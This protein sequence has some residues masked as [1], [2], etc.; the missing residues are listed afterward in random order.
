M[1]HIRF[2]YGSS[3]LFDDFS[4]SVKAGSRWAIVGQ[5]GSGKST[6]L[7]LIA[8]L[9]LVEAGDIIFDDEPVTKPRQEIG[10]VIQD[11]GLLPWASV[12]RNLLLGHRIQ[13]NGRLSRAEREQLV[14]TWLARLELPYTVAKKYPELLSGGQ[15]QRV[16]IGRTLA[17]EPRLLL[18]DEPFASVDAFT[19]EK[20]QSLVLNLV[21]QEALTMILVTHDVREAV[22]MADYVMVLRGD[23]NRASCILDTFAAGL[24]PMSDAAQA[25]QRQVTMALEAV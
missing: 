18:L 13:G 9:L 5:S 19:R 10:F 4:W 14:S 21:D 3:L 20:L 12:E 7:S 17:T 16:A 15:R 8:G 22:Y 23:S 24:D 11:Y 6:L 1:S 25:A 2:G